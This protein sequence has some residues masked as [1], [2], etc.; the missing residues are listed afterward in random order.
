MW[1]NRNKVILMKVALGQMNII[2][3]AMS[4]NVDT[5]LSMISQAKKTSRFNYFSRIMY[6]W[7]FI[8]R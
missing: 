4:K 8:S 1:Q 6:K 3:G 2:A 7:I 5:T